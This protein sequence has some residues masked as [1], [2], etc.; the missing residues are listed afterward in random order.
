ML[1]FF[2]LAVTALALAATVPAALAQQFP[3]KPIRLVVPY[4][5]GGATDVVARL[6]AD[7]MS[8][9][10]GQQIYVENRAGAG[11]MIGTS[12]VTHSAPD[13]YTLLI[14]DTGTYAL[15]PTLYG[16]KLTY[17]PV[18]DLSP[19][20][21]TGRVPLILTVNPKVVPV[22]N[23]KELIAAAKK[24]PGKFNFGAPGP[25]SPIHLAMELFRQ[26]AGIDMTAIPYKGGAD[27][28]NDLI[29][30][31]IGLLFVDAATGLPHIKAGTLK[32]L[33]VGSDKR[34]PT[35]PDVP[36]IAEAGGAS[37]DASAWNGLSAPAGTPAPVIARLN[38]ACQKALGD[39]ALR[40]RFAA[41]AVEPSP[42]TA[43]EFRAFIAAET[44]KWHTVI[45]SA[46]I[47]LGK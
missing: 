15:N 36:T 14:G 31:R 38:E 39:P 33:G 23:V 16:D 24:N 25:G 26:S 11:T 37:F 13:G 10:L 20:C 17:D 32:A 47:S 44:T 21:R 40:Q 35:L 43:E 19:V 29:G 30:G 3:A 5:A 2:R 34:I 7:R 1:S 28:L 27:A 6:V 9:D 41:L 4:P 18:K 45:T 8:K 12:A 46:G 42:S 22:A